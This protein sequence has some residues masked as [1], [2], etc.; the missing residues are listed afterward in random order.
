MYAIHNKDIDRVRRACGV[1]RKEAAEL[2]MR[3]GGK[4]ER[5]M[6]EH[7]GAA[8]VYVEPLSVRD[9]LEDARRAKDRIVSFCLNAR[10]SVVKDARRVV[11]VP[12]LPAIVTAL[13]VAPAAVLLLLTALLAGCRFAVEEGDGQPDVAEA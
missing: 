3:Y 6:T 1:N 7:F 8:R 9:P 4:P 13:A 2:L 10:L 12:L 11:S 5:V